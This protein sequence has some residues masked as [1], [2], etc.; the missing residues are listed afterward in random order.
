MLLSVFLGL[1]LSDEKE[2]GGLYVTDCYLRLQF[3]F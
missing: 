2:I 1:Y 3:V